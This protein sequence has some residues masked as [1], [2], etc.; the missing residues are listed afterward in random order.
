MP[1]QNKKQISRSI[2]AIDRFQQKHSVIGFVYA[3]IKKYQDDEAATQC[4]L[5]TYYGFLSLF[6]LLL[7]LTSILQA[8]LKSNEAL[9]QKIITSLSQYFP[10]FGNEIESSIRSPHKSG[11]ALVV[12]LLFILYGARGGADAFR[13]AMDKIWRI[14]K[15]EQPGFPASIFI[16]LK[17]ILFG[18]L[19]LSAAAFFSSLATSLGHSF[20]YRIVAVLVSVIVLYGVFIMLFKWATSS[21]RVGFRDFEMGAL[22]AAIGIELLHLVGVVIIKH[23]LKHLSILYGT[24]AVVLGIMFWIYLQA[25]VVMFCVE[26]DTVRKLKLWPRNIT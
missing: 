20:I 10:V 22:F 15:A 7:V 5:I 21:K 8:V 26:A 24:F 14:P 18:A 13:N 17:I 6:P 4:A 3:V 23:Q 12:G 19:G 16:S 25:Q 1:E 2:A 9:H 11:L